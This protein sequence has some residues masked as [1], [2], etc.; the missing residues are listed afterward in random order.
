MY[1]LGAACCQQIQ[2]HQKLNI[3]LNLTVG[4]F[5]GISVHD[6]SCSKAVSYPVLYWIKATSLKYLSFPAVSNIA[7]C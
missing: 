4:T 1:V 7:Q 3:E 5:S 6:R 2:I